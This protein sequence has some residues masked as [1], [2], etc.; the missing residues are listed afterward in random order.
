MPSAV[1][2]L[3]PGDTR[4]AAPDPGAVVPSRNFPARAPG[5][6]NEPEEVPPVSL[7][8][9]QGQNGFVE[10]KQIPLSNAHH[11]KQKEAYALLGLE[12]QRRT[13]SAP[14]AGS[15][16]SPAETGCNI[17]AV[18]ARTDNE[19]VVCASARKLEAF[20]VW[21]HDL[22]VNPREATCPSPFNSRH[23]H[24]GPKPRSLAKLVDSIGASYASEKQARL[25]MS[26]ML[27]TFSLAGFYFDLEQPN[28]RHRGHPHP[29]LPREVITESASYI[30]YH[31][32]CSDKRWN[33]TYNEVTGCVEMIGESGW[34]SY[35]GRPRRELLSKV[36]GAMLFDL[37]MD[38]YEGVCGKN[39]A[40]TKTFS[41]L[42][43]TS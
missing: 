34:I 18:M 24:H 6:E 29:P 33:R 42:L 28:P 2:V 5:R 31:Q 35:P 12:G 10:A 17:D 25:V 9:P 27:L 43:N 39:H 22:V 20:V 41:N 36:A 19:K 1:D 13:S 4:E 38:D 30:A 40:L 3:A 37:D 11:L 32:V 16:S 8:A 14:Y 21:S 26:R 7:T 23:E 15:P